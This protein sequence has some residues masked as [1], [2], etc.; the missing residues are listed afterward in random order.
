VCVER[1]NDVISVE[2]LECR[3]FSRERLLLTCDV[4]V[5]SATC[6]SC[7]LGFVILFCGVG[8]M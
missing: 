6:S 4:G 7:V 8:W 1:F 5:R 3:V 2:Q